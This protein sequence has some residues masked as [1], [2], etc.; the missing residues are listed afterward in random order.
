MGQPQDSDFHLGLAEFSQGLEKER[1]L[2]RQFI[3]HLIVDRKS[4]FN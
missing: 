2:G 1:E 3:V 4:S